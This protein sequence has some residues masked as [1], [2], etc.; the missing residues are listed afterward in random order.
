[1]MEEEED[2]N[3]EEDGTRHEDSTSMDVT[4]WFDGFLTVKGTTSSR[5]P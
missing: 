2:E 3:G 5:Y 4:D 1:M